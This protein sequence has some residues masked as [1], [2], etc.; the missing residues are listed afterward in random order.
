MSLYTRD[1]VLPEWEPI[2][3][4]LSGDAVDEQERGFH[5]RA[6]K[7]IRWQKIPWN[8]FPP[9]GFLGRARDWFASNDI[10]YFAFFDGEDLLLIQ[11]FVAWLSRPA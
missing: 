1:G 8:A 2:P 5:E 10:A 4:D 3:C 6:N 7:A 11:K 9:E